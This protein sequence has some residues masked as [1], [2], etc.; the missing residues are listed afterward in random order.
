[1][2]VKYE[3]RRNDCQVRKESETLEGCTLQQRDQEPEVLESYDTLDEAKKKDLRNIKVQ[4]NM[5][6]IL[7]RSSR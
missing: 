7:F 2:S 1:M 6:E 5:L 3:I 4:L